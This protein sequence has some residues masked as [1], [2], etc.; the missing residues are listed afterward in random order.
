MM[1][2]FFTPSTLGEARECLTTIAQQR[3]N[4]KLL[5]QATEHQKQLEKFS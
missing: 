2:L 1:T 4:L 5:H 3:N